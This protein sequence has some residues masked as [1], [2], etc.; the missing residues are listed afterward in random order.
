MTYQEFLETKIDIAEETGFEVDPSE[1]NPVLKPHQRDS[2][3]WAVL[4]GEGHCLKVSDLGSPLCSLN[5]AD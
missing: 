4:G 1:V 3:L 5:G 2:V